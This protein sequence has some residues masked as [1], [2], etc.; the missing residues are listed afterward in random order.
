VRAP[1]NGEGEQLAMASRTGRSDAATEQRDL[2]VR[3]LGEPVDT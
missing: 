2:R 3:L 1:S